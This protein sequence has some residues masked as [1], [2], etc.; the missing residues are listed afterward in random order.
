MLIYIYSRVVESSW[1]AS[2]L[3]RELCGYSAESS[4]ALCAFF[5]DLDGTGTKLATGAVTSS[6]LLLRIR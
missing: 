5:A 3:Q 2:L 6:P 1:A 4:A